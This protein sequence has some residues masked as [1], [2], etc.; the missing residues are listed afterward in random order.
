[1][2][3]VLRS[4]AALAAVAS[5]WALVGPLPSGR[6][7]SGVEVGSWWQG[8]G[9][10]P[11]PPQ[12]VPGGPWVSGSPSGPNAFSAFR[13]QLAN[14][15]ARPVVTLRVRQASPPQTG[16]VRACPTTRSWT[17]VTAGAW[18]ERPDYDCTASP[19]VG[20]WSNDG[21]TILLDLSS[22]ADRAIDMVIV[23]DVGRGQAP[24]PPIGLPSLP[25]APAPEPVFDLAFH[26]LTASDISVY[27]IPPGETPTTVPFEPESY[28]PP[29]PLAGLQPE[30]T[31]TSVLTATTTTLRAAQQDTPPFTPLSARAPGRGDRIIAATVFALLALWWWRLSYQ[32]PALAGARITLHDDPRHVAAPEGASPRPGRVPSL[33]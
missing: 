20:Q 25:G 24:A 12:V 21:S 17:A 4:A 10:S 31:T 15:Q 11:T 22:V 3:R 8:G 33:R 5:T 16:G 29:L 13:V 23:P 30:P 1:M 14:D 6:A 9:S 28:G 26:P 32:A 18:A 7:V 2:R 27:T 19:I